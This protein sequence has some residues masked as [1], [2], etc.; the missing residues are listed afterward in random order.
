MNVDG[1]VWHREFRIVGL[2]RPDH[3]EVGGDRIGTLLVQGVV[4]HEPSIVRLGVGREEGLPLPSRQGGE[5]EVGRARDHANAVLARHQVELGMARNLPK[6]PEAEG[7]I[8]DALQQ[9][10]A[11]PRQ[12]GTDE[13]LDEGL[14]IGERIGEPIAGRGGRLL[15]GGNL[16]RQDPFRAERDL[17]VLEHLGD[18]EDRRH[19]GREGDRLEGLEALEQR[20]PGNLAR[21]QDPDVE[22]LD[23]GGTGCKRQGRRFRGV[24]GDVEQILHGPIPVP[25]G[26]TGE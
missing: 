2:V 16:A 26:S 5:A 23:V 18:V 20:P 1:I 10:L 6:Q 8:M 3:Q 14:L 15:E 17:D 24:G 21:A 11:A 19:A 9:L 25:A 7:A 22:H 4:F 13:A 12:R